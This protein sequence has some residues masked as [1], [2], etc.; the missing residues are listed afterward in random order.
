VI[1]LF[2]IDGHSLSVLA[3]VNLATEEREHCF[4]ALS[5][6]VVALDSEFGVNGNLVCHILK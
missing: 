1:S 6:H 5:L 4:V 3:V 2:V